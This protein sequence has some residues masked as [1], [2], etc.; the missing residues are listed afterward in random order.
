MTVC[1]Q[2]IVIRVKGERGYEHLGAGG[3]APRNS[4]PNPLLTPLNL[5]LPR[6]VTVP[7][8]SL[9]SEGFE[10]AVPGADSQRG[11]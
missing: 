7:A 8:I 11:Y 5:R 3:F 1:R 9:I 4:F 2:G 6:K 10:T